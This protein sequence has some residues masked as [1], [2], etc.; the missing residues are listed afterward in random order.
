VGVRNKSNFR[1]KKRDKIIYFYR[2]KKIM[3]EERRENWLSSRRQRRN[4]SIDMLA[5]AILRGD[6]QAL[7][8]GITLVESTNSDDRKKAL[9]LLEKTKVVKT[10]TIRIGITGVPGVGK[11]TFIESFGMYLLSQG[12][13]VAVLAVDPSST[14][15]KGSILGD[16]TRMNELSQQENVFIRPSPSGGTLGGLARS[17]NESILLCESA[18]YDVILVETVGVGQSETMVKQSVDFFLLLMLAGAGD[19]LQGIKRGI[20]ELADLL[21]IT[22]ADG[23]NLEAAKRAAAEYKNAMHLFPPN[24]NGWIPGTTVCSAIEKRGLDEIWK[25]IESFV[26][27]TTINGWYEHNRKQ[28]QLFW[29]EQSIQ[30][31]ILE[32]FRKNERFIHLMHRAELAIAEQKSNAFV[33]AQEIVSEIFNT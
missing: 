23:D 8:R 1:H 7:G 21:V 11:S 20:M 17:T 31:E 16:K 25:Q 19:E 5:A 12:K 13:R 28:Q 24:D 30:N 32:H 22:K 33:L 6:R 29:L 18:G 15:N 3:N 2:C 10:N 4:V 27:L 14:R 26:N 9:E